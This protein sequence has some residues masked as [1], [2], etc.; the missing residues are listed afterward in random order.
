MKNKYC[1][2]IKEKTN[3]S[4]NWSNYKTFCGKPDAVWVAR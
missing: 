4:N 3:K 2:C 1:M